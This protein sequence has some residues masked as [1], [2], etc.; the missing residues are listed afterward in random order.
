M[1]VQS[2]IA[3]SLVVHNHQ[4]LHKFKHCVTFPHEGLVHQTSVAFYAKEWHT[5]IYYIDDDD[6][7]KATP[8]KLSVFPA[9]HH[10]PSVCSQS[11]F[12]ACCRF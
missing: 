8:N 12:H 11:V 1:D 5:I 7:D 2:A 4:I 10:L 9:V 6:D 3:C